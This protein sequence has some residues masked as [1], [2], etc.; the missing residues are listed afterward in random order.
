MP[1]K[2]NDQKAL[3]FFTEKILKVRAWEKEK[4]P[5]IEQSV[6]AFD[7]FLTISYYTLLGEPLSLKQLFLSVDFSE[8][9]VRIHLRRLL[10]DNWCVLVSAKHD[11]RLRYVVAQP[12]MLYGLADYIEK[13][14]HEYAQ[15]FIYYEQ[16]IVEQMTT[17]FCA[18]LKNIQE[19]ATD[20]QHPSKARPTRSTQVIS[21]NT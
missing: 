13:L 11:R 3:L 21:N 15:E 14:K 19:T 20:Y 12:K 8:A 17:K 4:L 6:L 5:S 18:P 16:S 9:G 1:T 10:R 7:I 2:K